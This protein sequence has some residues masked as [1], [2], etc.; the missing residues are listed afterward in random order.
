[1]TVLDD[2]LEEQNKYEIKYGPANRIYD[3]WYV[4]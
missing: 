2:Y 1:M 4:L 3:G